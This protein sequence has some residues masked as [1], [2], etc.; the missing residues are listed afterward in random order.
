M[1]AKCHP[2]SLFLAAFSELIEVKTRKFR[3]H[4]LGSSPLLVDLG[5]DDGVGVDLLVGVL[6]VEILHDLR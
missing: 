3:L 5:L 6:V 4:H 2:I 1:S